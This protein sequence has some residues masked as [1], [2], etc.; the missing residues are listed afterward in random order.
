MASTVDICNLALAHLGNAASVASISPPDNSAEAAHCARFYPMARATLL[1]MH[2]WPFA[3]RR[4][5]LAKTANTP[6]GN[7]SFEYL[8]PTS[9]VRVWSVLSPGAA[10]DAVS[11]P[12]VQET[13]SDGT[14][15]L[16]SNTENAV[17]RYTFAITDPTKHSPLFDSSLSVLL[18]SYI[19]GPLTK[20]RAVVAAMY[21]R[22]MSEFGKAS[23]SA[24]SKHRNP[25]QHTPAWIKA[26]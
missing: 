4:E 18:A 9:C 25:P 2:P 1:E 21:Q 22:F 24:A 7:W 8:L 17:A 13:A 10:D 20:D 16:L 6:G 14:S 23:V 19:A 26:R 12:F 3:T 5:A 11:D 15:V